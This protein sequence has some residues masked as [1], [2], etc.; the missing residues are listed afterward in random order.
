MN[1]VYKI[2]AKS[3][4]WLGLILFAGQV[5]AQPVQVTDERGQTIRWET[6]PSRVVSLLPSLT[7]TICALGA[8][9]R[10]VGVD[11]YSNWPAQVRDLPKLGGGLD[12]QIEAVLA[13]RPDAV[14]MARSSRAADQLVAL[15]LK[16]VVLEPENLADVERVMQQ[17]A[18][19]LGLPPEKARE[20]WRR[21]DAAVAEQADALPAAARGARVYFEVNSGPYGASEASF[22]GQLLGRLGVRNILPASMGPF[23]K[24]NPEMVVRANPDLIMIGDQSFGGLAQRPGWAAMAAVKTG[25]MCVFNQADS[26]ALVRP[27]PRMDEA[28]R[29]LARCL[30]EKLAPS[31][32]KP[33]AVKP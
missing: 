5:A 24:V 17:V 19:A 16:V 3:L 1:V 2:G 14:F 8:C 30:S 22:I 32:A 18:Q 11:R 12:P 9:D 15:G 21:I 13:M 26:D 27:G 31:Q 6:A 33:K 20:A 4:S 10:L 28:V 25:R 7:E 29:I 23:P